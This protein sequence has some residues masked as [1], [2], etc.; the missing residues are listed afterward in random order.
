MLIALPGYFFAVSLIDRMGRLPM[1]HMGFFAS[2]VC[3]AIVAAGYATPLRTSGGGAGFVFIYGLTYFFAN[4]GPNSTT[5]LMPVEA[6]PTRIRATA[7]GIS[8]AVGK[9]GAIVG[10]MGLLSMWYG[11]CTNQ[12]DSTGAPNCTAAGS[13]SAAQ[14]ASADSGLV[15]ILW[16]CAGVSLAGNAM[17]FFFVRETGGRSLEEVDDE[18]ETLR[19]H[20]LLVGGGKGAAAAAAAAAESSERTP[21]RGFASL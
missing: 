5:F 14:Q 9:C 21:L 3:F 12:L 7:H 1:T 18:C 16:L 11:F 20:D 6:F 2:A 17:S 8:A 19:R 10:A 15:A 13:P 4:F